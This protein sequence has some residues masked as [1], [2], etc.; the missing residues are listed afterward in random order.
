MPSRLITEHVS[1]LRPRNKPG[2]TDQLAQ[3]GR[4]VAWQQDQASKEK[5]LPIG[6][7]DE[8]DFTDEM[9]S[10]GDISIH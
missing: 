9:T 5:E 3:D 4:R 7:G 10:Y 6:L 2:S 1:M 8:E